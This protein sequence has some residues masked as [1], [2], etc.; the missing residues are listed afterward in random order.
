VS[1]EDHVYSS[2]DP[3]EASPVTTGAGPNLNQVGPKLPTG[4]RPS[5][6]DHLTPT[7]PQEAADDYTDCLTPT[8]C[9]QEAADHSTKCLTPTTGPQEAADD[10]QGRSDGGDNNPYDNPSVYA[11]TEEQ[12]AYTALK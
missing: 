12:Q 6:A 4:P 10:S 7:G 5:P 1:S 11:N 3:P 2:A 8:T 9:P